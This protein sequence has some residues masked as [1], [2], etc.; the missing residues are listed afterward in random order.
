MNI[1]FGSAVGVVLF[2]LCIGFTLIYR[3]YVLRDRQHA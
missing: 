2:I 3:R 1:G